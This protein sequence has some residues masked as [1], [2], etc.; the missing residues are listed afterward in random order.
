MNPSSLRSASLS[1]GLLVIALSRPA[2]AEAQPE[3]TPGRP[4]RALEEFIY[5][6]LQ[7]TNAL[8]HREWNFVL[9]VDSV[10]G[11]K[12][13]APKLVHRAADGTVLGVTR[14]TDGTL[15]VD[16]ARNALI[17]ELRN[18]TGNSLEVGFSAEK[19][20][21]EVPLPADFGKQ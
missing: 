18:V 12:L 8:S 2:I 13:V 4:N 20:V 16:R 17:L 14:A 3:K 19:R 11:K 1:A 7:R 9:S 15:R 5:A 6:S 21:Y 10:D